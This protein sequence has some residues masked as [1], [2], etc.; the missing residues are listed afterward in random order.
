MGWGERGHP[1]L[2]SRE[3]IPGVLD[4]DGPGGMR[5]FLDGCGG[6]ARDVICFDRFIHEDM[7]TPKAYQKILAGVENWAIPNG[8]ESE[9][10]MT[11]VLGLSGALAAHGRA[12]AGVASALA[13]ALND[14]GQDLNLEL[15][16]GAALV[17]DL[18]KG[19]PR[20]EARGGEILADLGLPELG[21]VVAAHKMVAVEPGPVRETE[22]VCLADKLV[23]GDRRV[24]LE[25]RFL[26]RLVE[27]KGDAAACAAVEMRLAMARALA[28]KVE[29]ALGR[30][31]D[32]VV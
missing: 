3:L 6:A 17:H 10:L 26:A 18:A 1:P 29:A 22:L 19:Q 14:R 23:Q 28:A 27:F 24:P 7:D 25:D 11:R 20:H 30:P 32:G 31:L 2:I 8:E 9:I 21:R 13:R 16:H 5:G 12:V 15:V 4:Y